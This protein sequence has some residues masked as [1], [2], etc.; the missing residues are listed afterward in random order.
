MLIDTDLPWENK[1]SYI[2]TNNYELGWKGGALLASEL[3][4]G[5]SVALIKGDERNPELRDRIKGAK[6][7]LTNVGIKIEAHKTIENDA[8]KVRIVM[9][10]ILSDHPDIKGVYKHLIL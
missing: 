4:P 7:S 8:V 1:Q 2:G 10:K 9:D 6:T 5:D 3:Q